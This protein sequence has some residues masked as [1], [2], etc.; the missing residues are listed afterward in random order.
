MLPFPFNGLFLLS[1]VQS[2]RP[3]CCLLVLHLPNNECIP[4]LFVSVRCGRY[5]YNQ[6][7]RWMG[8]R[9]KTQLAAFYNKNPDDPDIGENRPL[10]TSRFCTVYRST[11]MDKAPT[12]TKNEE[13]H[14]SVA[15]F[16]RIYWTKVI[17]FIIGSIF[18]FICHVFLYR[19]INHIFLLKF[20]AY[21]LF[22][23]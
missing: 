17:Y 2:N 20:S 10:N 18:A 9:I 23:P 6:P 4:P 11:E 5:I 21:L 15:A 16:W 19:W 8:C 12:T 7:G 13:A 14:S 22:F 1:V 3:I